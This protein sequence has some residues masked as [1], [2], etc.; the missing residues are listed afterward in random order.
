MK[1]RYSSNARQAQ[2]DYVA[3]REREKRVHAPVDGRK[4][5]SSFREALLDV[6]DSHCPRCGYHICSCGRTISYP[7]WGRHGVVAKTIVECTIGEGEI[8]EARLAGH[9][10]KR[11]SAL[12]IGTRVHNKISEALYLDPARLAAKP[13]GY[14]PD[15]DLP[16]RI[17]EYERLAGRTHREGQAASVV[18][19]PESYLEKGRRL[20]KED[21]SR[22]I[23][24]ASDFCVGT[25]LRCRDHVLEVV[26]KEGLLQRGITVR[27][28]A[29]KEV[30][31]SRDNIIHNC[32]PM[33][34]PD[35]VDGI[36]VRNRSTD[37]TF[38]VE[39][40]DLRVTAAYFWASFSPYDDAAKDLYFA[41]DWSVRA[42][43]S[44]REVRTP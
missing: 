7:Y 24:L 11:E 44:L 42:F 34:W 17:T 33:H 21:R 8:S 31:A 23:A 37:R 18:S 15:N 36:I 40:R 9:T 13:Y 43:Q 12:E 4:P 25:R 41:C 3:R 6:K 32:H 39:K 14:E 28:R 26:A 2:Y 27:D 29:G 35:P 20:W 38:T 19:T 10:H 22:P 30:I 1:F 16:P 5:V